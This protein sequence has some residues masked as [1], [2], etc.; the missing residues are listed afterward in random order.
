METYRYSP[1]GNL[2]NANLGFPTGNP[3]GGI[4]AKKMEVQFQLQKQ[5]SLM[6]A[7]QTQLAEMEKQFFSQQEQMFAEFKQSKQL[8][9]AQLRDKDYQ[10]LEASLQTER[11][12]KLTEDLLCCLQLLEGVISSPK[13]DIKQDDNSDS[14][15]SSSDLKTQPDLSPEES[16][17]HSAEGDSSVCNSPVTSS[18]A[19]LQS[20]TSACPPKES[21]MDVKVS[22]PEL[23]IP[24]HRR[25]LQKDQKF[26]SVRVVFKSE[27]QI[28]SSRRN[29]RNLGHQSSVPKEQCHHWT[30]HQDFR[31]VQTGNALT[32]KT[33]RKPRPRHKPFSDH[34]LP[35]S[36]DNPSRGANH[37][38][39]PANSVTSLIDPSPA[40]RLHLG[41]PSPG[42]GTRDAYDLHQTQNMP[43]K[44]SADGGHLH[45]FHHKM[46]HQNRTPTS[47]SNSAKVDDTKEVHSWDNCPPKLATF[48]GSEDRQ[49]FIIPFQRICRRCRW[50]EEESLDH[51]IISL[52]G[53]ASKFA[54]YLP[55]EI[56]ESFTA[57]QVALQKR[58]CRTLPP[59]V[60]RSKLS[61]FCQTTE[62]TPAF[63]EEIQRLVSL[64][65][66]DASRKLQEELA[67]DAFLT[68]YHH[69]EVAYH[70]MNTAPKTLA[71][72]H[73]L[74]EAAEYHYQ[75]T[76]G[77][78]HDDETRSVLLE[79]QSI[80]E[81]EIVLM[82]E[83]L[84]KRIEEMGQLTMPSPICKERNSRTVLTAGSRS[85]QF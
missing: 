43:S 60:M 5:Q 67:V 16:G 17:F 64:A 83:Q 54:C 78:R 1:G 33:K 29:N 24:P 59:H 10:L 26:S 70:V 41:I 61:N 72:A 22:K 81:H 58:F 36:R 31:K 63:A 2:L 74:V 13:F 80:P 8:Y 30:Q 56:R 28:P 66:P 37:K 32:K 85:S 76:M 62:S 45:E 52:R 46:P 84:L 19:V 47:S 42:F 25:K 55:E 6:V 9:D 21:V 77:Q 38:G 49:S 65:Y 40:P 82:M 71:E 12:E 69:S 4:F 57:L 39:K 18:Q 27:T 68:G 11:Y 34:R 53:S 50:N 15:H 14:S 7:L 20:V 35:Q 75:T 44:V 79:P 73:D 23:Y 51:L 3:S 48:D